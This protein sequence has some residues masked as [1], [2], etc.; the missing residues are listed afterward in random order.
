MCRALLYSFLKCSTS[1][2]PGVMTQKVEC[3]LTQADGSST[4]IPSIAFAYRLN[5]PLSEISY[6]ALADTLLEV[7]PETLR[8]TLADVMTEALI[9]ALAD[10]LAEVEAET[11]GDTLADVKA[12]ALLHALAG[13]VAEVEAETPY[14][15]LR[16]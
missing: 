15:T 5:K 12:E 9:D 7:E 10:T 8:N 3:Q 11:L 1:C 16:T 14:E 13:T 6:H 2:G 4:V